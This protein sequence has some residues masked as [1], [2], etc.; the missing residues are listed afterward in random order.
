MADAIVNQFPL[1]SREEAKAQG[2]KRYFT[3]KLCPHGHISERRTSNW[4]CIECCLEE[5]RD[6]SKE[7][8]ERVRERTKKWQAANPDWVS[9]YKREWERKNADR[10]KEQR[11]VRN[12]PKRHEIAE[13]KRAYFQKNRVRLIEQSCQW[14]R[15]NKQKVKERSYRWRDK[16]P[17]AF[18]A[19]MHRRRAKKASAEGFYIGKDIIA[20]FQSQRGLCNGCTRPLPKSYHVDHIFALS[21]GGSNWPSN[22]QLLC[23]PCNTSK[24]TKTMDEWRDRINQTLLRRH[25]LSPSSDTSMHD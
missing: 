23:A 4:K 6:W 16:N 9:N 2:L 24:G 8:P 12:E 1:V 11:K 21:R 13:K 14:Q 10:L 22:L 20:L 19:I 7:N 5:W 15:K 18:R 17:E 25:E 3:G